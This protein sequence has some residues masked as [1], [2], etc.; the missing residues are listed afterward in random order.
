M[1]K[2]LALLLM[3]AV[4]PVWAG[5]PAPVQV[6]DKA[7]LVV[8]H[9]QD[10]NKW[11]LKDQI[12][13]NIIL[14]YFYPKDNTPGCT[15][16]ACALRDKLEDFKKDGVQVIGVSMDTA[17][18]HKRFIFKYNLNFPLLVDTN[19]K[20]AEAYGARRAGDKKL[21]RRISFLI[22]LDGR[23]AEIV[24]SPNPDVHIREMQAAID[25]LQAKSQL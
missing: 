6:G 19:G 20:I 3:A 1:K 23:I 9:D 14:L 10:G 21:D 4:L 12:G 13:R 5:A 11:K 8:G 16:E 24:D 25:R 7:P 15:K 18:S 2:L 17:D 22:G